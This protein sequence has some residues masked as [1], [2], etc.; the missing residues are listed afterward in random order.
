MHKLTTCFAT[1]PLQIVYL[2]IAQLK[3][4]ELLKSLL[5]WQIG[6]SGLAA[7]VLIL[8]R[9]RWKCEFRGDKQCWRRQT[10]SCCWNIGFQMCHLYRR[11]E[12]NV[13]LKRTQ[14][15][16]SP[17]SP[18]LGLFSVS[19]PTYSA[20]ELNGH[21]RV[22]EPLEGLGEQRGSVQLCEAEMLKQATPQQGTMEVQQTGG[23]ADGPQKKGRF[24]TL[25]PRTPG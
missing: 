22:N 8:K 18:L 23:V 19:S 14:H 21:W 20:G 12:N 1:L 9:R 24:F 2:V 11:G 17:L 13:Y 6:W 10:R 15:F 16:S 7:I 5:S 4:S 3:F 25:F